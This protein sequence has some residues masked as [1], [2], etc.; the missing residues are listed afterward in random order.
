[1]SIELVEWNV[2]D[3]RAAEYN[4]RQISKHDARHLEESVIKF[5]LL[6]PPIVNTH[7]DRHGVV[8]GG[9]QR[10]SI[11]KGLLTKKVMCVEVTLNLEEEKE[12]NIRLNR[13]GGD[14]DFDMLANN[15]DQD[16]LLDYGFESFDFDM[17]L[18]IGKILDSDQ[19][20]HEK[21]KEEKVKP[22]NLSYDSQ[23]RE[24]V[25]KAL[26]MVKNIYQLDSNSQA[27]QFLL[28]KY[29]SSIPSD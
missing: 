20:E 3:L 4:P 24:T 2:S 27:V 5:G 25:V 17:D 9:H 12:L 13:N 19:K 1:M 11:V 14:F 10:L 8:V 23:T 15:F 16:D 7:P 28:E 29:L 21:P 6:Q 26:K 22:I 18:D